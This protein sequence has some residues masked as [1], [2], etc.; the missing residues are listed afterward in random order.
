[1]KNFTLLTLTHKYC[2]E[3]EVTEM[4]NNL[5][6]NAYYSNFTTII[7]ISNFIVENN[8]EG[9]YGKI[10]G[11]VEMSKEGRTWF[12]RGGFSP[13]M[14]DIICSELGIENQR[15]MAHCIGYTPYE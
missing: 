13:D 9:V 15:S 10:S 12:R 1:M 6:E 5:L 3:P 2:F 11:T 4:L 14:Y 8:L 7:E